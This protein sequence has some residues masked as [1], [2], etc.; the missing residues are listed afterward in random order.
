MT[1]PQRSLLPD[2]I[3]VLLTVLLLAILATAAPRA[4]LAQGIQRYTL[5]VRGAGDQSAL[6]DG[7]LTLRRHASDNDI[8]EDELQRLIAAAPQQAKELLA[9]EGYFSAVVTVRRDGEAGSRRVILDVELGPPTL[10]GE[11]EIRFVGAIADGDPAEQRRMERLRERWP[12]K[13]GERFRQAAWDEA[14]SA[15]LNDLLARD[16][17]AAR[18]AQSQARID[19]AQRVADLSLEADS[20][21]AFTFGALQVNGLKRYAR[22]RI[23]ALNPIIAGQPY[24]QNRLNE[25]QARLQDSGYFKSVF[26]TIEVDPAHP[27]N[28]PVRVDVSENERRRLALGGG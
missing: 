28:V 9:T 10:I 16:Y 25:L 5:E 26:A 15:L 21:P 7:F 24:S 19:P 23:D 13:S 12:L 1:F 4:A 8:D 14:K 2:V 11:V 6:L 22:S 27:H 3:R 20:G 17:P 18:L